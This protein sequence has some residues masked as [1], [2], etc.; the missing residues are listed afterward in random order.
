[1]EVELCQ[2]TTRL[3]FDRRTR[4]I[5]SPSGGGYIRIQV[6]GIYDGCRRANMDDDDG[7]RRRPSGP[8]RQA[9]S[10]RVRRPFRGKVELGT[11]GHFTLDEP[12]G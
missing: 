1:M 9:C 12:L 7:S 5:F 8:D 3:R 6:F 4:E 10:R 11:R 2:S